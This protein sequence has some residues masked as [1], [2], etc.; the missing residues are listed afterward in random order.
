MNTSYIHLITKNTS[1]SQQ[2]AIWLLE[3]ILQKKY[4]FSS[5][6]TLTEKQLAKLNE[7][8]DQINKEHVPLAYI[9]GW[10]PFLDLKISVKPPILI[11]RPETEEWVHSLIQRLIPHQ[12]KIGR[13]LEIGT[14]SGVIGL[15]LAKSLP[16]A[17]IWAI[18]INAQAL[19]LARHNANINGIKN[20]E[21]IES[22]L[23]QALNNQTFDL[24][25]SN[26][27]YIPEASASE[28]ALS[29]TEWE[30]S[31]AL[32]AGDLGIDILKK[33]LEQAPDYLQ[34]Q[35]ELPFQL[36]LEIDRTQDEIIPKIGKKVGFECTPEKDLFG[37]WRTIWCKIDNKLKLKG[38]K[39]STL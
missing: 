35:P 5:D 31:R 25:V 3:H 33:I 2:E 19:D 29:V 30:D 16:Q 15:A 36:V 22:D 13:I 6:F 11:P 28:M 23:F 39:K 12:S 9:I 27:P 8:I 20:I 21:F 24:I 14:G 37:N 1:L 17:Q 4:S 18:D 10:V 38:R 32:F 7:Y 26:P 34:S